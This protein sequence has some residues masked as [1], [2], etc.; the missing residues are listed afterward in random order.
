MIPNEKIFLKRMISNK[1]VFVKSMNLKQN[2]PSCQIS[3]QLLYNASDFELKILQRV[4]FKG[5]KFYL[6]PPHV[7]FTSF[8]SL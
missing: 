3:Y 1:K 5:G 8:S 6:S 2:F 4:R 7:L